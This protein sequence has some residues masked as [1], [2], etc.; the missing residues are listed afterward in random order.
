MGTAF[1]SGLI[2]TVVNSGAINIAVNSGL[3]RITVNGGSK[4][5]VDSV[6]LRGLSLQQYDENCNE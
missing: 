3:V 4:T 6:V 2:R 1:N 5:I